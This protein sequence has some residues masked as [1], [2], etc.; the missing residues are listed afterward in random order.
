MG[1]CSQQNQKEEKWHEWRKHSRYLFWYYYGGGGAGGDKPSVTTMISITVGESR[2]SV[3]KPNCL[4][5]CHVSIHSGEII[6]CRHSN[7]AA[8][9]QGR[10]WKTA[11]LIIKNTTR[12]Q[13]EFY[14]K[15]WY[16]LFLN[17][18]PKERSIYIY[19][20]IYISL[21]SAWKQNILYYCETHYF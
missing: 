12:K 1:L 11:M 17:M 4:N 16:F 14:Q 6:K 19:I 18:N 20:Y 10:N 8:Y 15:L 5:L 13:Y 21:S 3:N 2:N 9:W 7:F